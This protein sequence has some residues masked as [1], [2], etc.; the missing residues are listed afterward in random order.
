MS[1]PAAPASTLVLLALLAV[2][3]LA[4]VWL[5][6]DRARMRREH[7]IS[8]QDAERSLELALATGGEQFWQLDLARRTLR[9][10]NLQHAPDGAGQLVAE[11]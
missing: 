9:R 1:G 3:C 8:L 2:L 6:R 4:L 7:A 10:L 11:R 5:W